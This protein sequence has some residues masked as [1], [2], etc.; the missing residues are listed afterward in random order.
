MEHI[1]IDDQQ[2]LTTMPNLI[3]KKKQE[4]DNDDLFLRKKK[5]LRKSSE[6]II[7]ISNQ[8]SPLQVKEFSNH[9]FSFQFKLM[10]KTI[11]DEAVRDV[12]RHVMLWDDDHTRQIDNQ[13]S[14]QQIVV[15][16]FLK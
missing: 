7:E 1:I 3:I 16:R 11:V 6:E 15:N 8:E 9:F 5:I 4:D 12:E 10:F 2:P 14:F 13:S